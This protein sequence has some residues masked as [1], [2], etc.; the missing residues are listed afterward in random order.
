MQQLTMKKGETVQVFIARSNTLRQK[1]NRHGIDTDDFHFR[2]HIEAAMRKNPKACTILTDVLKETGSMEYSMTKFQ[3][4]IQTVSHA[5]GNTV[6]QLSHIRG[7]KRK[8]EK[9]NH[10]IQNTVTNEDTDESDEGK[11]QCVTEL[12][13]ECE[14]LKGQLAFA[15][16]RIAGAKQSWKGKGKGKGKAKGKGKGKGGRNLTQKT[17]IPDWAKSE[18]MK[19]HYT[20]ANWKKRIEVLENGDKP[21]DFPHLFKWDRW[22]DKYVCFNCRETG[23]T[24]DRCNKI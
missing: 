1:L 10:S 15:N 8:K 19:K 2:N 4:R 5:Y 13:K 3:E 17:E 9:Q 14:K 16:G 23:H 24:M 20:D 21:S 22:D 12:Q 6:Q 7:A 11:R 18:Y